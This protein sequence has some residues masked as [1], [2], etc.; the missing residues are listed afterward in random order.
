VNDKLLSPFGLKFHPFR[1]EI[2]I[3]ALHMTAAVDAFC[4]R[5]EFTVGDGG[6]V[7]VTGEPGSGKSVALRLLVHRLR[8]LRDVVVGTVD[9][10]QS[11]VSD[12]YREL[13]DIF[14][15][16]FPTHNRWAGFKT[17]RT[18]WGEHI[19]T[20]L[21]RPV[22]IIDEAQ[23]MLSTVFGELRVLTSKEFDS[24][25]L[26]CVVLAGDAR[27]P[28][29]LR[30]PDLL[31][32]GGRIRRRLSL[33]PASREELCACLDHVLDAA[34]NPALMT[35]ELK[36][37]LAEHAA[38]NYRVMMN[39][40]DELL[41]AAAEQDRPQLDEQLYFDIFQAPLAK[42]KMASKKRPDT[43]TY[44]APSSPST[45]AIAKRGRP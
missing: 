23:E 39:I 18:R 9:H 16:P 12:F 10:P 44:T 3:E 31:P 41:V 4:N 25:S 35:T 15:V 19:S 28:E 11:R 5:V 42:S 8:G 24:R 17:L 30:T 14:G 32:L 26:L 43:T 13:G 7:M 1:P 36:V 20:T 38:G 22:L 33:E 6:F 29:R 34:G 21:M 40:G 2:P 45:A 37:T 27:L